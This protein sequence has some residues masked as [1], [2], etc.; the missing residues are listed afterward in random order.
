M[1]DNTRMVGDFRQ[2]RVGQVFGCL[3]T[4][5]GSGAAEIWSRRPGAPKFILR[6]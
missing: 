2:A 6:H 1:P 3:S 4:R 5:P